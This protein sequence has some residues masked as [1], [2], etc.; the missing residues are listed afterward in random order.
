[1]QFDE[2]VLKQTNKQTNKQKKKIKSTGTTF[3][4]AQENKR[5]EF[6]DKDL[7]QALMKRM[8][9][10]KPLVLEIQFALENR[11]N[12]PMRLESMAVMPVNVWKHDGA[13]NDSVLEQYN[14][15]LPFELETEPVLTIERP[16]LRS[17]RKPSSEEHYANQ[18][19]E[20]DI[21]S[22]ASPSL[23][24][25]AFVTWALSYLINIRSCS[26]TL[27]CNDHSTANTVSTAQSSPHSSGFFPLGFEFGDATT[28][29]SDSMSK[30]SREEEDELE[31]VTLMP[32]FGQGG[33]EWM[34]YDTEYLSSLHFQKK[35]TLYPGLY[36]KKRKIKED[37]T[38]TT[39]TSTRGGGGGGEY[40]TEHVDKQVTVL[41]CDVF[42]VQL[43]ANEQRQFVLQVLYYV[44][45]PSLHYQVVVKTSL[46]PRSW[47]S[48]DE[49]EGDRDG[50]TDI[51]KPRQEYFNVSVH[52]D[53]P[54][55]IFDMLQLFRPLEWKRT[56]LRIC[57]TLFSAV[58]TIWA[59]LILFHRILKWVYDHYCY[60]NYDD[61][62][63]YRL[64]RKLCLS[65]YPN[66][67]LARWMEQ[68]EVYLYALLHWVDRV[69]P[70]R[71]KLYS[72]GK[73]LLW[74]A[75]VSSL[76][77]QSTVTAIIYMCE[78][79]KKCF[80][81][82]TYRL[83]K[84][85]KWFATRLQTLYRKNKD[86]HAPAMEL[87]LATTALSHS[88]HECE[89]TT[90]SWIVDE[91]H[92]HNSNRMQQQQPSSR[93]N[94]KKMHL[95]GHVETRKST[96]SQGKHTSLKEDG[97]KESV[98]NNK[99]KQ[100]S[101]DVIVMD[102]INPATHMRN[103]KIGVVS[104]KNAERDPIM[105]THSTGLPPDHKERDDEDSHETRLPSHAETDDSM[106]SRSE[107]EERNT[108]LSVS[109]T[110]SP[111]GSCAVQE[112][113]EDEPIHKPSSLDK[114]IDKDKDK[115]KD[116]EKTK[117]I[118]SEKKN[119]KQA[120]DEANKSKGTEANVEKKEAKLRNSTHHGDHHSLHPSSSS[121]ALFHGNVTKNKREEPTN[122]GVSDALP[123]TNVT[124][125]FGAHHNSNVS[126]QSTL[127][128]SHA[129]DLNRG[130]N[131]QSGPNHN[132]NNN[133]N[134]VTRKVNIR[135]GRENGPSTCSAAAPI[136]SYKF[137]VT[138]NKDACLTNSGVKSNND[139]TSS[140]G[141][142]LHTKPPK[143]HRPIA[144]SN[145]KVEKADIEKEKEKG[146]N[147][148]TE[149]YQ[150]PIIA[151]I[152][153]MDLSHNNSQ[154]SYPYDTPSPHHVHSNPKPKT[155]H[156]SDSENSSTLGL[157]HCSLLLLLFALV[158]RIVE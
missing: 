24:P 16:A 150:Q 122:K 110:S 109:I 37:E 90:D 21:V 53:I 80:R 89:T 63:D 73:A 8:S 94:K 15:C 29:S 151:S 82:L 128:S 54:Q 34:E 22:S 143:P 13:I 96:N 12:I 119:E 113:I 69:F 78:R 35:K 141:T 130:N 102:Q 70:I 49:E 149:K 44:D 23:S 59:M 132:K 123:A 101:E 95:L 20:P 140:S 6:V 148:E 7:K 19:F 120:L 60:H 91:E 52:I 147:N 31:T 86:T 152:V 107:S 79:A 98:T 133:D 99:E 136:S 40:E 100:K 71:N 38:Q 114:D 87:H 14:P 42:P 137:I 47:S 108:Q 10:K 103:E 61:E 4:G 55:D 43:A 156:I 36:H 45:T 105:L 64:I 127:S 154:S 117:E 28:Q 97:C 83:R 92:K 32:L 65:L 88:I 142:P 11:G 145:D 125:R 62:R 112:E 67:R 76:L 131:S 66:T 58:I 48:T 50:N 155:V 68:A 129:S 157:F 134:G 75:T 2:Y 56:L 41:G 18:Y 139:A 115:D 158:I 51:A 3:G 144:E 26:D 39:K 153:P 30:G 25:V 116:K 5:Y 104:P 121:S 124:S 1:M 33:M 77:V 72:L 17:K 74:I 85:R 81:H 126:K 135:H 111:S 46:L 93:T 27:D 106:S 118:N 146:K 9:E 57:T 138:K 84:R